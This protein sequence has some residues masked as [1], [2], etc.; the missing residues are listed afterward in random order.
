MYH[1]GMPADSS[2]VWSTAGYC[3]GFTRDSTYIRHHS[4]VEISVTDLVD[5]TV[6]T[7]YLSYQHAV[8]GTVIV[9]MFF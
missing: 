9:P 2:Y 7:R 3:P 4:I 6:P 1:H 8:F 5:N